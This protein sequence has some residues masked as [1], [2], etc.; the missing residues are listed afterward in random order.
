LLPRITNDFA[1]AKSLANIAKAIGI[2]RVPFWLPN[3]PN[4]YPIKN[5]FDYL[6][7]QV[8]NYIPINTSKVEKE[9][10]CQFYITNRFTK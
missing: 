5:S 10:A 4:L 2:Q 1:H 7:I 8:K 3:S 6:K 9:K